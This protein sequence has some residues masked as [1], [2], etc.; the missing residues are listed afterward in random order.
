MIDGIHDV[1]YV[2]GE[3]DFDIDDVGV[4]RESVHVGHLVIPQPGGV[5]VVRQVYTLGRHGLFLHGIHDCEGVGFCL[6]VEQHLDCKWS[7]GVLNFPGHLTLFRC[8]FDYI[9]VTG[10]PLVD[11]LI[12]PIGR[13]NN[14]VAA[15]KRKHSFCML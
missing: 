10:E 1:R 11:L 4:G 8:L 5:I 2:V 15:L 12:G 13:K 7:V 3:S 6:V 14:S 9:E